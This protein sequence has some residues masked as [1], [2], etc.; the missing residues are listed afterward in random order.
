MPNQVIYEYVI[1]EL[2]DNSADADIVDNHFHDTMQELMENLEHF[3]NVPHQVEIL[4]IEGNEDSGEQC[5][6][7]VTVT[8]QG[9]SEEYFDCG[10]MVPKYVAKELTPDRL[11]MIEKYSPTV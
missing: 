2:E 7:Y 5:R 6:G 4:R 3:E 11:K 1:C 9:L 8:P 10:N